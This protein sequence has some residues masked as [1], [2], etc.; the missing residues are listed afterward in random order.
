MIARGAGAGRI[1]HDEIDVGRALRPRDRELKNAGADA[2]PLVDHTVAVVVDGVEAQL[3]PRRRARRREDGAF[4]GVDLRRGDGASGR[5]FG[6]GGAGGEREEQTPP[7]NPRPACRAGEPRQVSDSPCW[8]P[9]CPPS[10][11]PA[12]SPPSPSGSSP[13]RTPAAPSPRPAPARCAG[14]SARPS[15][16]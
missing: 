7:P 12:A 1:G 5:G 4:G 16:S 8:R 6:W 9:H 13:Q 15:P 11:R 14:P 10:G 2:A 3:R